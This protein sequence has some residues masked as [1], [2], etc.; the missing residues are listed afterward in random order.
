MPGSCAHS[1][2]GEGTP[3][4][5]KKRGERGEQKIRSTRKEG[6]KY[7]KI[8]IKNRSSTTESVYYINN[9]RKANRLNSRTCDFAFLEYTH[10]YLSYYT[11]YGTIRPRRTTDQK[12]VYQKGHNDQKNAKTTTRRSRVTH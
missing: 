5:Q 11:P 7:E 12:N 10:P 8:R 9:V 3:Y 6:P 2:R 4:Q 1:R